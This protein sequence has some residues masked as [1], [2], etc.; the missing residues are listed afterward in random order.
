MIKKLIKLII[1]KL[2]KLINISNIMIFL[3]LT[4]YVRP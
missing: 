4:L 2:I 1:I 3:R